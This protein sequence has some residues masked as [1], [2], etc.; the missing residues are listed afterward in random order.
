MVSTTARPWSSARRCTAEACQE[1]ANTAVLINEFGEISLDHLLLE[2]IDEGAVILQSGCV[3]CTIRGDLSKAIRELYNKRERGDV[4]PFDRLT[5][6]TTGLADPAPII[7]TLMAD[8]VIR[9]H[10]RLGNVITTLDALHGQMQL[11]ANPE[12]VKQAAVAD[13]LV[14]AKTDI[15]REETVAPL[16]ETL[17]RIN[18]TASI[19]RAAHEDLRP[20]M[21]FRNDIYDPA[22]KAATVGGWLR[23]ESRRAAD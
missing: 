10:F 19:H 16:I 9:H 7:S 15:A 1:A 21:L 11:A 14:I 20:E 22:T 6:E 17:Y 13:H 18:P 5:I 3:C 4:P 8:P 23:L 12:S 2:N